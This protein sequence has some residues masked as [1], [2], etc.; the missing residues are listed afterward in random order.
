MKSIGFKYRCHILPVAKSR[1]FMAFTVTW[2]FKSHESKGPSDI[3]E[4]KHANWT[5]MEPISIFIKYN[6]RSRVLY[7]QRHE[8]CGLALLFIH[9]TKVNQPTKLNLSQAITSNVIL[10]RCHGFV[11]DVIGLLKY[12]EVGHFSSGFGGKNRK[13]KNHPK[14]NC[15]IF[16]KTFFDCGCGFCHFPKSD[17]NY[18]LNTQFPVEFI[19]LPKIWLGALTFAVFC[20]R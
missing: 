5:G 14:G 20:Y 2:I 16:M 6:F 8:T 1:L 9:A 4:K 19:N 12:F 3:N 15:D 11:V 17:F 10:P 7:F 13:N 18:F